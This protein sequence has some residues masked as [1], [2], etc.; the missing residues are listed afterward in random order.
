MSWLFLRLR[1]LGESCDGGLLLKKDEGIKKRK[2]TNIVVLRIKGPIILLL[3]D[4]R[5]RTALLEQKNDETTYQT[6]SMIPLNLEEMRLRNQI[7]IGNFSYSLFSK[8]YRPFLIRK[9]MKGKQEKTITTEEELQRKIQQEYLRL[10]TPF[11]KQ[12]SRMLTFY[13]YFYQNQLMF[14][15]LDTLLPEEVLFSGFNEVITMDQEQW[16]S[17][18]SSN[19]LPI[20]LP[21]L[22]YT[23]VF[24]ND[25]V[26][27]LDGLQQGEILLVFPKHAYRKVYLLHILAL[28]DISADTRLNVLSTLLSEPYKEEAYWTLKCVEDDLIFVSGCSEFKNLQAL[29]ALLPR[30]ELLDNLT[31]NRLQ[32]LQKVTQVHL[33]GWDIH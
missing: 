11:S 15:V 32:E 23:S 13:V 31:L 21:P 27:W 17:T 16:K 10:L 7:W 3:L 4:H 25:L 1:R 5:R 18:V 14:R 2:T 22:P 20:D 33:K 19:L 30:I 9:L 24:R 6:Q 29:S 26:E 8:F 28:L 12:D